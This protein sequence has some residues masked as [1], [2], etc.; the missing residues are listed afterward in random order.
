MGEIR[1][2][3]DRG[4][5][6]HGWLKSTTRFPSP[7]YHDPA[8][9]CIRAAARDQRGPRRPGH[10]LRHARPS[11]H[12]NHQLRAR[13]RA[14][15]Q[16]LDGQRLDDPPGDVQRMSAGSG[17]HA[18]RVQRVADAARALPADLDRAERARHRARIR[19]EA[20]RRGCQARSAAPD[21][22]AR[23]CREGSVTHPPGRARLRRPV[24]RRRGGRLRVAPGAASICTWR[25]GESRPTAQCSR[26][27]M[28]SS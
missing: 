3:E 23:R 10:G 8:H 20:L 9:M 22:I 21:R 18:Q 6:D 16:G 12:G 27:G 26:L 28:R 25:G 15:A 5:A 17:V 2:S 1:R 14:G 11:R 24:R 7:D 4:Y 13:R 19:G